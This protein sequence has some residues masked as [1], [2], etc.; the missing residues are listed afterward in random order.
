MQHYFNPNNGLA[1]D[2][3]RRYVLTEW[4]VSQLSTNVDYIAR[5][6]P[7]YI[8]IFTPKA[9]SKISAV[10]MFAYENASQSDT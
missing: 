8:E 2:D 6:N 1:L 10:P 5:H 7:V 9:F 4:N 3:E